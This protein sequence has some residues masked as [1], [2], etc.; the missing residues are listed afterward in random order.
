ML[1]LVDSEVH[2]SSYNI[3]L[4][5]VKSLQIYGKNRH[6]LGSK[7]TDHSPVLASDVR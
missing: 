5:A 3:H 2:Y 1:Y 4:R 6:R 7:F